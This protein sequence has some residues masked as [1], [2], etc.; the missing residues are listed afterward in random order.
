MRPPRLDPAT[1]AAQTEAGEP[2]YV[3]RGARVEGER[4]LPLVGCNLDGYYLLAV[5]GRISPSRSRSSS[6]TCPRHRVPDGD[7]ICNI[8]GVVKRASE[9]MRVFASKVADVSHAAQ[10]IAA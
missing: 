6:A 3:V 10:A 7:A 5:D 1:V 2:W 4:F 9:A 8:L